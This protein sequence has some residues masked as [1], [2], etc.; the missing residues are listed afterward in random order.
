MRAL[1]TF[2]GKRKYSGLF[3]T[4]K[5]RRTWVIFKQRWTGGGGGG[6]GSDGRGG[7][8]VKGGGGC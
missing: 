3:V 5:Q 8:R 4:L 2:H 7:G 6:R 1:L